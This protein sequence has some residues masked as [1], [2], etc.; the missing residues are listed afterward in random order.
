MSQSMN[1]P[2]AEEARRE[3]A[4]LR[5]SR[6]RRRVILWTVV[7]LAVLAV[8]LALTV[9]QPMRLSRACE[10]PAL[11]EGA[12]VLVNRL[13]R[14]S[15]AGDVAIRWEPAFSADTF[16][17]VVERA[18]QQEVSGALGTVWLEIWPAFA[19]VR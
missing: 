15:R 9:A 3:L 5:R 18:Q 19:L 16:H 11:P 17:G 4:R 13:D 14:P 10:D 1:R 12:L 2:T 6:K 8:A 7:T